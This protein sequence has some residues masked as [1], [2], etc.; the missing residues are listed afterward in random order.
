MVDVVLGQVSAAG[1]QCNQGQ[2]APS[3]ISLCAPGALTVDPHGNLWVA[4]HSLEIAGNHRLLEYDAAL[5]PGSPPTA[6]FAVP[7]SRVFGRGGSF[8]A[9]T[10]LDALC[11]PFQPA[12][13]SGG[14]MVV[15]VNAY[16]GYPHFPVVYEDP[17]HRQAIDGY[18]NDFQSMAYSAVFDANHNLYLS[19]LN[20]SRVL[21]Y[22][23][24]FRRP[25]LYL[26]LL[27]K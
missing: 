16:L 10:C 7:A 5:F 22:R 4:D 19:D 27:L 13:D 9:T 11:G 2:G 15:G 17:L 18:L 6:L 20:R 25:R 24:P 8:T 1:M 12:F 3:R 26:P 21:I 23:N 14:Q